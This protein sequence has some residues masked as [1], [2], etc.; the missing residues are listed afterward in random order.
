MSRKRLLTILLY[1]SIVLLILFVYFFVQP[2]WGYEQTHPQ[3]TSFVTPS[4]VI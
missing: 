1:L 3:N 2:R 4:P